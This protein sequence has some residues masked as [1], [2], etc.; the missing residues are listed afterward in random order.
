M[1]KSQLRQNQED[2][3]H[4]TSV[5]KLGQE[6][7]SSLATPNILLPKSVKRGKEG[8]AT[9][10]SW[11]Y[12]VSSMISLVFANLCKQ[13]F[14]IQLGMC[15]RLEDS[16]R[17]FHSMMAL[18]TH[19]Q[20]LPARMCRE[21]KGQKTFACYLTAKGLGTDEVTDGALWSEVA[22]RRKAGAGGQEEWLGRDRG[23]TETKESRTQRKKVEKFDFLWC[24]RAVLEL[25]DY[26]L[27][28][29]LVF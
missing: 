9:K 20:I 13:V 4:I 21:A 28:N 2:N 14:Q 23:H 10:P 26:F 27:Y 8:Q 25:R 22:G 5:K 17:S 19:Q 24:I 11:T 3:R 6:I 29:L 18:Y 15:S 16:S 1:L 7:I 12:I